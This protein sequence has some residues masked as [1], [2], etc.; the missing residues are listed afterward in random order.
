MSPRFIPTYSIVVLLVV[1]AG[2]LPTASVTV[3]SRS[4]L[5]TLSSGQ[6]GQAVV[7]LVTADV[8]GITLELT[9]PTIAVESVQYGG[10]DYD[11]L[12]AP[13]CIAGGAAGQ[14]DLP[15]RVVLLGIPP[16]ADLHVTTTVLEQ[17]IL[18]G[19]YHV[20]PVPHWVTASQKEI[21]L[22][23]GN[24]GP[25]EPVYAPDVLTYGADSAYP[26]DMAVVTQSGYM[27]SQRVASLTLNPFRYH[28]ASG[29]LE[30]IR[31]MRVRVAFQYSGTP[32]QGQVMSR[33]EEP[34]FE[35]ILSRALL[36]PD[37][38]R[39]WRAGSVA[40]PA[41]VVAWT[42]PDPAWKVRVNETGLYRL[43]YADLA[44]AGLPVDTL[45][46][47]TLQLYQHGVEA[48]VHVAGQEDGSLD[49]GDYMEFYGLALDNLYTDTNVY[50]L[51]CGSA[52]GR[53]MTVRDGTPGTAPIPAAFSATVR[54]EENHLYRSNAPGTD[55]WLWQE[56]DAIAQPVSQV[57]TA[58]LSAVARGE[59]AGTLGVFF[60]G[61]GYDDGVTPDHHALVY[62]NEHLVADAWWDG[63]TAY[64]T[65]VDLPQTYLV[66]GA[67]RLRVEAPGDSGALFDAIGVNSFTVSYQRLYRAAGDTLSFA[68]GQPGS[69]QFNLSGFTE[70]EILI[71]DV[72]DPAN[73]V[74]IT[75]GALQ[76]HY[77]VFLP[78]VTRAGQQ[79]RMAPT[80]GTTL[81]AGF[82]GVRFQDVVTSSADYLALAPSQAHTPVSI[83]RDVPSD[84]ADTG[85]Q[86]DY[87][88][89]AHNDLYSSTLP[90]AS[91]WQA[92]GLSVQMVHLSDVY[93]EF[94]YGIIDPA[95]IRDLLSY[96]Y[97]NW[98]PPQLAY[99]LLVGDGTYD[100]RD[101]LGFGSGPSI[102]PYLVTTP[103]VGETASDNWL[104]CVSGD[105][106]L[107]DLHI[108]RLPAASAEEVEGMVG[109]ILDYMQSPPPGAWNQ[110]VL[111]VADNADAAG[112]FA[113]YSDILVN[114]YLPPA[115]TPHKVYYKVTHMTP[116]EVTA[117]ITNTVNA[118]TVV[119][120]YIGHATVTGWASE[121]LF[122]CYGSRCDVDELENE[123]RLPFVVSM[124]CLDGYYVHPDPA[125]T[126]LSEHWLRRDSD[127]AMG[128]F[129]ASGEGLAAGH[130]YMNR[131]LFTALFTDTLALG[132]ATTGS[133]L[134]L[135]SE[136]GDTYRDLIE[137]Y[138]LFGDPALPLKLPG[139]E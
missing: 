81:A 77:G 46:P 53:R 25:A 62:V 34:A 127:G 48:A 23:G 4:G 56:M 122:F 137:T 1:L 113:A 118:G 123:G 84:L 41:P 94:S 18:P 103:F 79:T 66:N 39:T 124:S 87:V 43:T 63:Q 105:D 72:T 33:S 136:T 88:I 42:P 37:T 2:P 119:V 58:T 120:N 9:T 80:A 109:K 52:A 12:V 125:F 69:W 73:V 70:P 26:A 91:Y 108:G 139:G 38:A 111:F 5:S 128:V 27:R 98:Q 49:D 133:K 35:A 20:A 19:R 97:A 107:P 29:R 117:A 86:I 15:R 99:V 21:P 36:N 54:V 134:Y 50:W 132:P 116:A 78:V 121:K 59:P 114:G 75:G 96:G 24:T 65:T 31:H 60:S 32:G 64:S 104:A 93:D 51:T 101:Y 83:E 7:Q 129:A 112:N 126:T 102:P 106:Y 3:A 68:Q 11:A 44:A 92:Q 47:R 55:H 100:Y 110:N 85:Q 45:D 89:I 13:G 115:Y 67:N 131:S 16:G 14:P 135:Y 90:L 6:A 10:E 17:E 71:L 61:L 138:H 74:R 57:F 82:Y 30:W 28:P 40:S 22:L 8:W 76:V 95:A 130:D